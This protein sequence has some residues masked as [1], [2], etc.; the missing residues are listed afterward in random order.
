MYEFHS[1]RVLVQN[2]TIDSLK[3]L[4]YHPRHK[5]DRTRITLTTTSYFVYTRVRLWKCSDPW[6]IS[7]LVYDM[8]ARTHHTRYTRRTR[9]PCC[10]WEVLLRSTTSSVKLLHRQLQQNNSE[11]FTHCVSK[12]M[13]LESSGGPNS[14]ERSA[15]SLGCESLPISQAARTRERQILSTRE[16]KTR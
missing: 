12:D 8:H 14:C 6:Y 11:E 3:R 10:V 2:T 7:Y 16:H 13:C 1:I 4:W 9:S 5:G 15:E